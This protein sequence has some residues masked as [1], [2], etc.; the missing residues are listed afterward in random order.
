MLEVESYKGPV[1]LCVVFVVYGV[2]L[3]TVLIFL[4]DLH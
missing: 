2:N 3:V 4:S 1:G